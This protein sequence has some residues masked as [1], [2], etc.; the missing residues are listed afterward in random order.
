MGTLMARKGILTSALTPPTPTDNTSSEKPR[1]M[2]RGAVG[3]L[4]STL[5][6][7]QENAVQDIDVSLIDNAGVEDRL[8]I[9]DAAQTQL[10]ESIKEYGQQVPVLLRPHPTAQGRYEIVYGR[11]RLMALRALGLPVKAMVRH[12]DDQ[13][14]VMAQG[15]ENN[16]RQDLSFIEKASFAAQLQAAGYDR[17]TIA[18]ALSVDMP[19]ISR[20]L[21]VGT[22]FSID[23][24]RQIGSAP[25]IGRDRWL[26]LADLLKSLPDKPE[27]LARLFLK[28]SF[29]ALPSDERFEMVLAAMKAETSEDAPSSDAKP[30]ADAIAKPQKRQLTGRDGKPLADLKSTQRG[31]TL[32]IPSS[33]SDGFDTWF[34]THAEELLQDL[35]GRWKKQATED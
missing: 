22:A 9:D 28:D 10:I 19:M 32:T 8:G 5:T 31:V 6:K 24:L 17:Q 14:L 3:A 25:S 12:L 20:F 11:R 27:R 26:R 23:F 29:V 7:L 33:S 15:Q 18:A 1:L 13:A 30:K 34:E 4:Q 21:K 35:H 16:A 2:P